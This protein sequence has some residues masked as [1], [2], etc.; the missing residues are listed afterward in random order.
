MKKH[1]RIFI[2]IS[3]LITAALCGCTDKNGLSADTSKETAELFAMDTVM[4]LTAY[5]ENAKQ[6]INAASD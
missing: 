6:A 1:F 3:I 4:N 5:G 2:L